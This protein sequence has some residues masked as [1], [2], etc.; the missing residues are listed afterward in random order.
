MNAYRSMLPQKTR[1]VEQSDFIDLEGCLLLDGRRPSEGF[2]SNTLDRW[3]DQIPFYPKDIVKLLSNNFADNV[4]VN[5]SLLGRQF[6]LK[7]HSMVS[8]SFSSSVL[9]KQR[10]VEKFEINVSPMCQSKGIGRRLMASV[11]ELSIALGHKNLNFYAGLSNGCYTWSKMG[12]HIDMS[13]RTEESRDTLFHEIISRLEVLKNTILPADV[14]QE[15]LSY[16]YLSKKD[17]LHNLAKM[18]A[19]VSEDVFND[20]LYKQAYPTTPVT[21]KTC[22]QRC[23]EQGTQFTLGRY[24]LSGGHI[25]VVIDY[26]DIAQME[27][28]G[29]YLGGW[30]TIESVPTLAPILIPA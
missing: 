23:V 17:D 3:D 16:A 21:L 10:D 19:I 13:Y 8:P 15:A 11:M 5:I 4:G 28:I 22:F 12:A 14:Y 26:A 1:P 6:E 2:F 18:T 20:A 9:I 24:L 30:K 7:V 25:P 29:N 27:S